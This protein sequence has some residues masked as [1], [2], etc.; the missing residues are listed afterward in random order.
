MKKTKTPEI[1]DRGVRLDS[2]FYPHTLLCF[3]GGM[4]LT[5]PKPCDCGGNEMMDNLK[6]GTK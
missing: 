2:P 4:I 1:D 6:K 5:N 3:R